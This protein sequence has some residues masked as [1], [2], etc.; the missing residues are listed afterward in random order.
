MNSNRRAGRMVQIV[1]I[2]CPSI[3]Y[4]LNVFLNTSEVSIYRVRIVI[5][6]RTIIEWS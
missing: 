3:R 1:S 5:R 4:L 2:S 6:T